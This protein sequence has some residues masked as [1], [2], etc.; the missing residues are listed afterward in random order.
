MSESVARVE[1]PAEEIEALIREIEKV[2]VG[3]RDRVEMAL[4]ALLAGG[5]LIIEDVPGV[6]KTVLAQTIASALDCEFRRIQFT[7]DLLPTDLLGVN[8]YDESKSRFVFKRGPLFAN[9]VLADEINRTS[10]KT[11]SCLLEAMNEYQITVDGVPHPLPQPFCVLATQNP[12]EFEGTYPLPESQLD[13]FF[14]RMN[15]GYPTREGGK[16]IILAQRISHPLDTVDAVMRAARVVELQAMVRQVRVPAEMLEYIVEIAEATRHHEGILVGV[17]PRAPCTST[18][19]HRLWPWSR[20]ATTSCPMTSSTWPCRCSPTACAATGRR[21]APSATASRRPAASSARSSTRPPCRCNR[22]APPPAGAPGETMSKQTDKLPVRLADAARFIAVNGWIIALIG[23]PLTLA[24]RAYSGLLLVVIVAVFWQ[25]L[26]VFAL[27]VLPPAEG[28][29]RTRV[30]RQMTRWGALYFAV[31][32]LF[33]V[34]SAYWGVNLLYLTASFLLG[35]LAC[36]FVLP[37]LALGRTYA[38]WRPPAHIFAGDPF[39]VEVQLG[40]HNRLLSACAL[41]VGGNDGAV[42]R[43]HRLPPGQSADLLILQSLAERGLQPLSPV[44]LRTGFPFGL[45]ET[46]VI[47]ENRRDVLV[48]PHLGHIHD[49]TLVRHKG[50]EARWLMSLRRRDPQGE[51]HSLREYKHGDNP[52]H[53]H[54]PTS[55]RLRRLFVREF[56]RQEMHSVLMLLDASVPP[57]PKEQ[58]QART[59]RLERAISFT[60]T[61]AGC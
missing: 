50:G 39:S 44:T 49:E 3:K 20:G 7:P 51:F 31:T 17:S 13:R 1:V 27:S 10:P 32:A 42:R 6:G 24:F 22:P 53:I 9:I 57:G 21:P 55:A 14:L 26:A 11:Q 48:Y 60:A 52:R 40:N 12:F 25:L 5:H 30:Y 46:F 43:I 19:P 29:V 35:G 56:E 36:S 61:L 47:N 37:R 4:V 8:I 28:V 59:E 33:C 2:Y 41:K 15:L 34:L 58:V 54:W 38:S 16:D 23:V 18:V 45:F